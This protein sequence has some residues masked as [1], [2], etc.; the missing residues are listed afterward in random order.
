[1]N[2]DRPTMRPA[3]AVP[4]L[5]DI[6]RRILDFWKQRR[7]FEK[8]REL[9]REGTPFRFVDGPITANN[10]MGVHHAWGRTLKDAF[11]RYQAM[12]GHSCRY[13]NGFDCQG[14]WLEVEVEK[15]LGF[16]GKPDIERFGIANFSRKCR[17]RVEKFS[18][19][20]A[21][22]SVRL[23]QWMDW[24][25]SYY[26]HG[27]G[28][29]LGIW[30]FLK[31]CK[32]NGWLA[33][34]A[35]PMPWCPRCG[36][37][38]SEHEMSGAHKE[39]QHLSVFAHLP[40][41]DD[42]QRRL[43]LWTTTPWTL[44]SNTAAAVNPDLQYCEVS[45]PKWPHRLILCKDALGKLK[46]FAPKVERMFPGREL[47]G[48]RYETFFPE[49]EAQKAVDHKVV[50]WAAVD[51]AE[52]SGI[53]HIAPGCG[54]EDHELGLEQGLSAI[55]PVD[56]NGV[57]LKGFGWLTGRATGEV[58]DDVAKAL[59]K[60]GKLLKAELYTHSY[61]V[62][63][64]CKSEVIFRLVD[65]WFIKTADIK[66]RLKKAAAAVQ[67][68]PEHL[69]K[70]ME[71]WLENMGD[72]CISRKRYWGM[73]L[74]FFA[75][76]CGEL[77]VAGSREE[78]RALAVDPAQVDAL[79]EL[80]KPWID[81]VAIRCPKCG[82]PVRR[83]VEVGDCWLDA[84]IVPYTTLGY[85]SD[86]PNWEKQFPIE[87]VCEMREQ[88][89]LWF[90]SMLFMGVTISDRAPYEKVLAYER[91]ISEEGTKFS[92]TGHMIHF[93]EA[94]EK[95][96]ADAMR[97]L[98]CAQPV[99]LEMRFG[100][101]L[102]E[103]AG[104]KLC[105][106]WNIYVFFV[107]YALVDKPDLQAAVPPSSC[108][109]ADRWLL[110]RTHELLAA[111]AQGY[112]GYAVNAVVRA[113]D[114]YLEDVSNWYVRI[115][116]RRFWR[117]GGTQDKTAAYQALH[118]ALQAVVKVLAPIT[119]FITEE[120]WQNAV[121][122]LVA[123]APESI[124]HADWP[125][126]PPAWADPG[127]LERTALVRRAISRALHLREDAD[128]R[129][130]QPLRALLV[131]GPEEA[132]RA[133][134]EQLPVVLSE[135][136]VKEVR[137][138]ADTAALYVPKLALNLRTAGPILRG[139]MG[140]VKGLLEGVCA[141]DMAKMVAKFDAGQPC[142]IAGHEADLPPSV[143]TREQAM[144]P[145]LQVATEGEVTL[146]LD[147]AIDEALEL[148]GLARDLVRH[149]QVL[150]KDAGLEVTQRVELGLATSSAKLRQAVAAHHEHIAEELLAVRLLDADLD[151]A[152]TRKELDICGQPVAAALRPAA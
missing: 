104:R 146:A 40:L 37:S 100:F 2:E 121:R 13:Q 99:A 68:M 144:A 106:L 59:E 73:P 55:G 132:V 131:H 45:S 113:V 151:G 3:P 101:N 124:H 135:L 38:L 70:R 17:E 152:A 83:V 9:R 25:H 138:L 69:G 140:K 24:E 15:E 7:A 33:R 85:F 42:P 148:E 150:R 116:R 32:E 22:Q 137:F 120:I 130:R 76:A 36:T 16:K 80:H 5:V 11:L 56:D 39:L 26:T 84:G 92:K 123:G 20:Q 115:N 145:G 44:S 136:N 43:L 82:K 14:L 64:R 88:V 108:T 110:A 67:W 111:A 139:D 79:P 41:K 60:A 98:Y 122:P 97:Y 8:L 23:G 63:W 28:N 143:F 93:D 149:L 117:S 1:M 12:R 107:T 18:R 48:L 129:V 71:D 75:C 114:E 119:P 52:G 91:M 51:A 29:I 27:D 112:D 94:V 109:V 6:E 65:E 30:H 133:L 66:P 72:W 96:G 50:P 74:P 142:R 134:Q 118:Q 31:L 103:L 105:A 58:A 147:T 102:G 19:I 62:C 141:A 4:A 53:V 78:L 21:E 128:I 34:K 90:Y 86:R 54:R 125:A 81:S 95:L 46:P 77:T 89:R 127:L 61:P 47:L 10:P 126:A 35:L 49:F 57:F 87:W